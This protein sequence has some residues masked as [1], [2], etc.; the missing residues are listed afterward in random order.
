MKLWAFGFIFSLSKTA[1]ATITSV[2]VK[3]STAFL[4]PVI[5]KLSAFFSNHVLKDYPN[6]GYWVLGILVFG[7]SL[8]FLYSDRDDP[9]IKFII[10]DR[11]IGV[12][13]VAAAIYVVLQPYIGFSIL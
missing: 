5:V 1:S 6:I 8:L 9:F 4:D 7:V 11:A 10:I 12:V 3:E 13:L 2:L